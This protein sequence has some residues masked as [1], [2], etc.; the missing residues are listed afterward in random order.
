MSVNA[1]SSGS[2]NR[3]V[4]AAVFAVE[5]RSSKSVRRPV[6]AA[7]IV[8]PHDLA[9]IRALHESGHNR[10]ALES[11]Q[12]IGPLDQWAGS[13]ARLLGGELAR[14][15]GAPRLGAMLHL[16]AW[17]RARH[18]FDAMAAGL[19][20]VLERQGPYAAWQRLQRFT[21][22]E[23]NAT[24]PSVHK[25]WLL[26]AIV[27]A[28]FR[29]FE[30]ADNFLQRA[31][32]SSPRSPA[33]QIVRARMLE[34]EDKFE[35]ALAAARRALD[36]HPQY[37]PAFI[38]T[39]HLLQVLGRDDE[40]LALLNS[41]A[42]RVEDVPLL[43]QLAGLQSAM[44]LHGQ[45]LETL[46]K[47]RQLSPILEQAISERLVGLR[48][49]L[50]WRSGNVSVSIAA[51]RELGDPA[52]LAFVARAEAARENRRRVELAVPFVAQH[53]DTCAPATMTALSRFWNRSLD[54]AELAEE[55]SYGG[56]IPLHQCRWTRNNGW[57][58][59][60]FTVTWEAACA[61]LDRGVPFEL[62]TQSATSGHA[63]A[64]CGYDA[65][66]Q[67][68]LIR[69][70]N[71][72]H[73]LSA[74]AESLLQGQR[75][76]GPT[77]L[78]LVPNDK[79]AI[80][81]GLEL[82]DVR[83]HQNQEKFWEALEKHQRQEAQLV[84]AS[85]E[86]EASE[87]WLTLRTGLALARYDGDTP[88]ALEYLEKLLKQFPDDPRL[89][90]EKLAGLA[91]QDQR[92]ERLALLS[93][94]SG[95]PKPHPLF[96][97]RYAQELWEDAREHA[98][99][100]SRVRR[101]LRLG[102]VATG[103][104]CQA[105]L[106]WKQRR[107]DEAFE[108]YRLGACLED[109][110][111]EP[112]RQYFS[113]AR[114]LNRAES[115]IQFL[116]AR[117]ERF[118]RKSPAPAISLC[119][120]L[121]EIGRR[122]EARDTLEAALKL[123]PDDASLQFFTAQAALRDG[124][125]EQAEAHLQQ[126]KRRIVPGSWRRVAA[127]IAEQRG[128]LPAALAAWR[129]VLAS[130]PLEQE[131]HSIVAGL[132]ADIEGRPSALRY[133]E[134]TCAKFPWHFGL[135]K[136]WSS[137]QGSEDILSTEPIVDRL[138]ELNPRDADSH[139]LK[140]RVLN[141]R[142]KFDEALTFANLAVQLDPTHPQGHAWRGYSLRTQGKLDEA[143]KAF[144]QA[145][146]LA[147]DY[148]EY[149]SGL[150]ECCKTVFER[151]LALDFIRGELVQHLVY[152]Q[153]IL[154]FRELASG[155]L[156]PEE[157]L[158]CL[159]QIVTQRPD[160]WHSW[161]ALVREL[162]A[163]NN[164]SE[165]LSTAQTALEKLPDSAPL[166]REVASLHQHLDNL[167]SEVAARERVL[168]LNPGDTDGLCR[169]AHA[170]ERQGQSD[171]A[172]SLLEEALRLQPRMGFARFLLASLL[173]RQEQKEP[174]VEQMKL[175]VALAPRYEQAWSV[176]G[177]WARILKKTELVPDV[178]QELTQKRPADPGVWLRLAR[179]HIEN[180]NTTAGLTAVE[181]SL[182]LHPRSL[183]AHDLRIS[184]LADAERFEEAL[185]AC[186]SVSWGTSRPP[187]LRAR[188][189]AILYA[190]G[191][192]TAAEAA[193]KSALEETP[194][195]LWGWRLL[196]DWYLAADRRDDAQ[197]LA[198][199]L[200]QLGARDAQTHYWVAELKLAA[201][202]TPEAVE[203]LERALVLNPEHLPARTR[204]MFVQLQTN[205]FNALDETLRQFHAQ[206][207]DDW[208]CVGQAF[209]F[210]K[211]R[212]VAAAFEQFSQL[213]S[214]PNADSTAIANVA[215]ALKNHG[216][217][218]PLEKVLRQ[219]LEKPE[220]RAVF[221][222]LWVE[223]ALKQGN[224]P[225]AA[226]LLAL[227][228]DGDLKR[229]T[230]Y[231]WLEAARSLPAKSFPQN[232]LTRRR[233]RFDLRHFQRREGEWLRQDF[234]GWGW[235]GTALFAVH[236]YG[237]AFKWLSDWRQRSA[238][239]PL[240]LSNLMN[241]CIARKQY[242]EA[243]SVGEHALGLPDDHSTPQILAT[244]AWLEA[245]QGQ[246]ERAQKRLASL[247]REHLSKGWLLCLEL[248]NT[249]I[250]VGSDPTP[251]RRKHTR[252]EWEKLR[253]SRNW[254]GLQTWELVFRRLFRD[255]MAFLGSHGATWRAPFWARRITWRWPWTAGG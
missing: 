124:Q 167:P 139:R 164:L 10:A 57:V 168:A 244:L 71:F 217:A 116:R 200:L 22:P 182:E 120:T 189:A 222:P 195:L 49:Q 40:A 158:K 112:A 162:L 19:H 88:L 25:L 108:L 119:V 188:E 122:Q 64:V 141:A 128:D 169:L 186:R 175:A 80:L 144:R 93:K 145:I 12:R 62:L 247:K 193:M 1:S 142:G 149:M 83:L 72:R 50:A 196:G 78:V 103:M 229:Q 157:L 192:R 31:E 154:A 30:A 166:W 15:M 33:V 9:R 74:A 8:Q 181:K 2:E 115:A 171:R 232:W 137:W 107:F 114:Q 127:R 245:N 44:E 227:C 60:L 212:N 233:V 85:M 138:L 176:L 135:H 51:A 35:G 54:Q 252:F 180:N 140:A 58:V 5:P 236:A 90:M 210:L 70:P 249:A 65:V 170:L 110:K 197:F 238:C 225:R 130:E 123:R 248:I 224:L 199:R 3:A 209:L 203:L 29:D 230:L 156:Q 147:V 240:L 194:T 241:V 133:L 79:A 21:L 32:K 16:R 205:Q 129:E 97:I 226:Q 216:A 99:A 152:G 148:G 24:N 174:A 23:P 218:A 76:N 143:Q 201:N 118:G 213:C 228:R 190:K 184:I 153:G 237:P 61:L 251:D 105:R 43:M 46:E 102:E 73:V 53:H 125:P 36:L 37:S 98:A 206:G 178:I 208:V 6:R 17:R 231:A 161:A 14:R 246:V 163:Q 185:A 177:H 68:L 121:E 59:R 38:A 39:A 111:E 87:H 160:L 34:R 219:E 13:H 243:M 18:D 11:A 56:T 131:A 136:L 96:L 27:A 41:A 254:R 7:V 172:K 211:K 207:I 146:S 235:F 198:Q 113:A 204:L 100:T 214:T 42:Q 253:S 187:T 191:E 92:D 20:A 67:M 215:R 89:L 159:R 86:G 101:A 242:R 91:E 106:L 239:R 179:F 183:E 255:T 94:A 48:M 109:T 117:F 84:L 221:G 234:T 173:W 151:R 132:L 66:Q 77:G 155:H 223:A 165:A 69:D 250:S 202:D 45:G 28:S 63:Q 4:G 47:I 95:Q 82:P 75:A 104:N 55:I 150:L 81:D 52:S 126:A 26:R 220:P 134:Q